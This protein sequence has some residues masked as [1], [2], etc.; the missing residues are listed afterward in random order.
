MLPAVKHRRGG[1]GRPASVQNARYCSPE[2]WTKR[3]QGVQQIA[4][5]AIASAA[6]SDDGLTAGAVRNDPTFTSRDAEPS[7]L[8]S[9]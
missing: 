4:G 8:G 6:W 1:N 5:N 3:R 7:R 2:P 9:S